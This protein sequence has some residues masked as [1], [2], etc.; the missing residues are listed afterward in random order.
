MDADRNA[1]AS[2]RPAF[3]LDGQDQPRLD[4]AL[5]RLAVH[6]REAGIASCEA[7]FGNWG[8]PAGGGAT[9][10][11]WF[12]RRTLDFGK[13]LVVRIGR[14]TVF[15]GRISALEGRFPGHRP[16][17]LVLRA[18]DRLQDLRMTRRSRVF[19]RLSDAD[20]VRR[21]AGDH[22]LQAQVDL[23]GSAVAL[24]AQVN[25]S[26]LALLRDRLLA[27]DADLWLEGT[28]LHA[29][30]RASRSD[31]RLEL[32]H[33]A[34]LRE[35][36]VAADLAH[37]R[38][39][40][41]CS[42]WDVAAKQALA[43][44]AGAAA[45]AGEASAGSSG[46]DELQQAFGARKDTVAHQLPLDSGAARAIAEAHLRTLARRFVRG[47]GVAEADARLAVGR[48]VTLNGL[49]PLFSGAYDV[50]EVLHRF[51][52]EQGLR[53]EFTAERPWLGRP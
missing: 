1:L 11:V 6:H 35:F 30:A 36:A 34:R 10:F 51:D 21:L 48:R 15:E 4:A 38:S 29:A 42:G 3:Q 12:D 20:L 43:E 14:S 44:E 52:A 5:L 24:I 53:S 46:P 47:R 7:E 39:A 49:G 45:I 16:P 50:V 31:S 19:E 33:G 41:V 28:T 22:G 9:G 37:Q 27:A 32:V 8:Q 26:D 23:S 18:E 2:A 25:Q 17:S 40:V 13:T